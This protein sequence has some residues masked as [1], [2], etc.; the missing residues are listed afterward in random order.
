MTKEYEHVAIDDLT[1]GALRHA[2]V[3]VLVPVRW[4]ETLHAD[5]SA[6]GQ[7]WQPML[8]T[9]AQLA[10]ALAKCIDAHGDE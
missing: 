5:A 2:Y 4:K 7:E 9:L 6:A 3:T 10:S 1:T 8:F